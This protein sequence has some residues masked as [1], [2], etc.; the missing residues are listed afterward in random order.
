MCYTLLW[1]PCTYS[2]ISS[3]GLFEGGT[4]YFLCLQK[5]KLRPGKVNSVPKVTELVRSR[6]GLGTSAVLCVFVPM[7]ET[8]WLRKDEF[9]PIFRFQ[10]SDLFGF[11]IWSEL[12][13][14]VCRPNLVFC[15]ILP[16][17][18]DKSE[19][20]STQ[21]TW[22]TQTSTN[23]KTLPTRGEQLSVLKCRSAHCSPRIHACDS[24]WRRPFGYCPPP[25][26]C[27]YH[28]LFSCQ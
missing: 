20:C 15:T 10:W 27:K 21:R 2:L 25:H 22:N 3:P 11:W 6:A 9:F 14:A 18:H 16:L 8:T 12:S 7:P 13:T 26:F 17:C 4:V 1:A 24:M 28:E 5:G 23:G 19:A